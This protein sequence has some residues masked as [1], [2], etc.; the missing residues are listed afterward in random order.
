M[1][2]M[3]T[4]A[5]RA[6][7]SYPNKS[8]VWLGGRETLSSYSRVCCRFIS[9]FARRLLRRRS[10]HIVGR[11]KDSGLQEEVLLVEVRRRA[12]PDTL[13][14]L[15]SGMILLEASRRMLAEAG[16]R[17]LDKAGRR[18][19][20]G[21]GAAGRILLEAGGWVRVEAGVRIQVEAGGRILVALPSCWGTQRPKPGW[22]GVPRRHC[23]GCR[24]FASIFRTK[25]S[26]T[27]TRC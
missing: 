14:Q 13:Q 9:Q 6:T 17:I 7:G 18:R 16:G 4:R 2:K 20:I 24:I 11:P 10:C 5:T 25:K 27:L 19:R 12:V 22:A 8:A 1:K 23:Y 3:R 26:E 15:D 21:V